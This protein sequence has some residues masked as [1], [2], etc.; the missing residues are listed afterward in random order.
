M[1]NVSAHLDIK[2]TQ[3]S[4]GVNALELWGSRVVAKESGPSDSMKYRYRGELVS[5]DAMI[6]VHINSAD[7]LEM[8]HRKIH[9]K[10]YNIRH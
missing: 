4:K 1:L 2:L 8:K 9:Q 7:R 6:Y 3:C 5:F 10:I